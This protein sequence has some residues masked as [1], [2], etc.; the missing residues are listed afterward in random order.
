MGLG[1]VKNAVKKSTF[2][3]PVTDAR[4]GRTDGFGGGGLK[5]L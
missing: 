3:H 1:E 2:G 5:M 4:V